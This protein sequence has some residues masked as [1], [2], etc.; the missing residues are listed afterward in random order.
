MTD[1]KNVL[2]YIAV[3]IQVL[4][5]LIYFNGLYKGK[6]KPHAFSWFVWGVINVVAFTAVLTAG[7]GAGAW[8]L[9]VNAIL[10][11]IVAGVGY[12]QGLVKY[13]LFDWLALAGG[14]LGAVL[15]GITKQ[16][17]L[18]VILVALSDGL[19]FVP[20]FR[21]AYRLPFEENASSFALGVVNYIIAI[22]ALQTLIVTTWLY[23]A[24]IIVVDGALVI[25]ILIRRKQL[26]K[27]KA[28]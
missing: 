24:E 8:T 6:T 4:S 17:F 13:D 26:S 3:T 9:G 1:Y 14:I 22:F 23:P 7:G 10:C 19:G 21:K 5:Y 28:V 27:I 20:S 16:P 12:R 18:A 2:G 15:W 25:L 11:F